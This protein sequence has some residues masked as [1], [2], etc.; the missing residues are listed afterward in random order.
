MGKDK[1]DENGECPPAFK[2]INPWIKFAAGVLGLGLLISGVI[3]GSINTFAM[4]PDVI[5]VEQ[6]IIQVKTEVKEDID[7][8]SNSLLQTIQQDRKNSDIRF[9]QQLVNQSVDTERKIRNELQKTPTDQY[10]N[11]Q[12]QEE[13][14]KQQ[15]Y[16]DILDKLLRAS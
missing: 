15:Q 8:A 3:W 9:Y 5:A 16:K 2:K 4:K 7:L 13:L 1:E 11:N 14:R 10:L 12:L 6:K